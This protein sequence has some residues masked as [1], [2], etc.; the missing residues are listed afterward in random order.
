MVGIYK[1]ENKLTHSVY[2]G[3]SV[4]ITKRKWEHLNDPSPTS[5]I[6][7]RLQQYGEEAFEFEII[8]ECL[9]EQLDAR[10]KYWI[11][12]YNSYKNGYNLTKGG[13]SQF[14]ENN[15]QSKLTEGE[16]RE[17]INLLEFTNETQQQIADKYQVSRN[18]IDS[19]NRCLV[20]SYLHN[21]S[22]NIRKE[23]RELRG[24]NSSPFSGEHSGS[25]CMTEEEVKNIIELLKEDNRSIAQ[26]SR[27]LKISLNIL[28]DINRCK[29]WKY[30]HN[31]NKNIRKE[32]SNGL[33]GGV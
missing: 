8:E 13:K 20:W 24:E 30:L 19:I 11:N 1:Y 15:I 17:I 22:N 32:Y 7:Q 29:I 26:L 5:L 18:T 6:D 4:N 33:K 9:P 23:A 31:F 3:Q 10:E 16:V 25:S 21:Y 2:I 28:Y 14:G 27:D 12:Y